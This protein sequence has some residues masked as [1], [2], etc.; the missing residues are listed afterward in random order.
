MVEAV[1]L[2]ALSGPLPGAL[3]ARVFRA[4]PECCDEVW[5]WLPQRVAHML[6]AAQRELRLGGCGAFTEPGGLGV[7]WRSFGHA[8]DH[9]ALALGRRGRLVFGEREALAFDGERC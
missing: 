1:G 8:R 3:R 6:A 5:A 9:V 2:E 4:F 7:R